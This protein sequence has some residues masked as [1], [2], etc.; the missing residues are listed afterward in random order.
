MPATASSAQNNAVFAWFSTSAYPH[1]T[2]G[3][4]VLGEPGINIACES[5]GIHH[6]D[7]LFRVLLGQVALV[8]RLQVDAPVDRE[9]EFLVRALEH[10]D[11]LAVIHTHEFPSPNRLALDNW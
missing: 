5:S 2:V 8:L 4:A 7:R 10:L 3:A 6:D 11:R 9:L 1:A